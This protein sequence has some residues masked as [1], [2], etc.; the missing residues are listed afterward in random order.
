[1]LKIETKYN[2]KTD[3][4]ASDVSINFTFSANSY[5]AAV[6]EIAATLSVMFNKIPRELFL[7]GVFA[8]DFGKDVMEKTER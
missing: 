4:S 1:M 5:T 7:D 2:G 6:D 3:D 8:S